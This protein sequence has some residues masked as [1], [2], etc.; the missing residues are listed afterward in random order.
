LELSLFSL[1]LHIIQAPRAMN[2]RNGNCLLRLSS[3]NFLQVDEERRGTYKTPI[4]TNYTSLTPQTTQTSFTFSVR[5]QSLRLR[6][7]SKTSQNSYVTQTEG[8]YQTSRH[9]SFIF[10]RRAHLSSTFY[11]SITILQ[12]TRGDD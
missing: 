5:V 8:S 3:S 12:T 11:T 9:F 1:Q 10:V 2:E 7:V 4:T 6:F